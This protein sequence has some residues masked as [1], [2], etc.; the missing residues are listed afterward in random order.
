[1][2]LGKEGLSACR[3]GSARFE[4]IAVKR[5]NGALYKTEFVACSSCGVTYHF[6]LERAQQ[7]PAEQVA[8][9][10]RTGWL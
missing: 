6:P 8:F 3:C 7:M 4:R 5:E 2:E 9:L 1:M 10:K